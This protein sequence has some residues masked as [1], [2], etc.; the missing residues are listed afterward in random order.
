MYHIRKFREDDIYD[1]FRI[2]FENLTERYSLDLIRDIYHAW[3]DGFFVAE[4]VD[5]VGFIAGSK[6]GKNARILMLA[7][8]EPYRGKGVGTALLNRFLLSCKS[9]GIET[10]SLEVR[11]N[12]YSAIRFYTNRGF[13]IVSRVEN[14]YSNGD[15]AYIMWRMI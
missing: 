11:V 10:V 5:V 2:A 9:E 8:D 12:N 6:Y 15:P 7:V 3:P 13:Q 4:L 1:V 14:Y